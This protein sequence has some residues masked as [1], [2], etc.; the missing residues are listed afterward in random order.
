[1]ILNS[2]T[3]VTTPT[4]TTTTTAATTAATHRRVPASASMLTSANPAITAYKVYHL[5]QAK[6]DVECR[7]QTPDLHR[8]VAHASIVDS[9]R[10]WS[11]TVAE[12]TE[13]VLVDSDS[14]GDSDPFDDCWSSEDDAEDAVN[15][16]E[17]TIFDCDVD[18][19]DKPA[20]SRTEK[21]YEINAGVVDHSP[22][23][24]PHSQAKYCPSPRRAAPPPPTNSPVYEIKDQS[25]RQNRPVTVRETAIEVDEDD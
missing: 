18:D 23:Q 13:T 21:V 9:V 10:R 16:A 4:T 3:T 15:R 11:R 8:I 20:H 2:H 7:R 22:N 1:M 5:G 14:E 25:W 19:E 12:P 17:V 6:L 24:K